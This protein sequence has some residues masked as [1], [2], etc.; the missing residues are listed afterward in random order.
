M[1]VAVE[2]YIDAAMRDGV[3][4]WADIFRP[5]QPTILHDRQHPSHILLPI[6]PR[7]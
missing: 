1:S 4:L 7:E 3:K 6:I 5:A 2:H